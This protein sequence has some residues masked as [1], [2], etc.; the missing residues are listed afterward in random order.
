MKIIIKKKTIFTHVAALHSF[1]QIM[2]HQYQGPPLP[3]MVQVGFP[4]GSNGKESACNPGDPG[5]I[6][7]LG[8]SPEKGMVTHSSILAWR[9]SWTAA[10]GRLQFMGLQSFGR[11]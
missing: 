3:F 2:F 5:L 4:S 1:V 10:P 6:P 7:G 9:I 11:D 8:R